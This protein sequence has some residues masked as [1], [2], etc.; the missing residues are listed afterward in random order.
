[1]T[2]PSDGT[3][4]GSGERIVC[5]TYTH[6]RRHPMVLG[7][8]AGW[9]PPFQLSVTQIVV[10]AATFGAAVKTWALWAPQL[11]DVVALVVLVA[12]PAGLTW[13]VR[14]VRVEGRSLPRAALGWLALWSMPAC[15]I[16][17]GR[18]H[19]ERPATGWSPRWVWVATATPMDGQ[20]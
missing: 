17:L 11:P 16:V 9:A 2:D 19:R 20:R 5:R 3:A 7:R 8:I 18:P 13:S 10:L 4:V 1:M 12:V 14:R 6:A 15:G